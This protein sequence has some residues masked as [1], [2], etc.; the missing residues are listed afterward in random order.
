MKIKVLFS[1]LIH[2][3][4]VIHKIITYKI[5]AEDCFMCRCYSRQTG[6]YTQTKHLECNMLYLTTVLGQSSQG[7]SKLNS[8]VVI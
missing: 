6:N 2:V 4:H 5:L 1:A 3:I 7:K 8:L